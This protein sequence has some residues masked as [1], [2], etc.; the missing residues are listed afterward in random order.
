[1]SSLLASVGAIANQPTIF[2][3]ALVAGTVPAVLWLLFWLR[4]DPEKKEP[5]GLIV[6]TF[7]TGMIAV[8][9]TIPI[10][11]LIQGQFADKNVLLVL[12]A[13]VEEII[14]F[15]VV[16][17]IVYPTG[18]INKPVDLAIY[19][20]ASGL[21]FAALENT[22]FLTRPIGLQETTVA[23][24]TGHL[25]FLGST[26]LH[27]TASAIIGVTAGLVFYQPKIF[28]FLS[29]CTG[30]VLAVALHSTFNFF[31]MKG[32]GQTSLQVFGFLWFV[33]TI[34]VLMFEKLRRMSGEQ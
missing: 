4:E 32:E 13:S 16:A 30:I 1:M 29:L 18:N 10:Q 3:V 25:R 27:A 12:W 33:T 15:I 11:K 23:L 2:L 17:V 34:N 21:G 22:L 14:K 24:L 9:I 28:R 20:I 6:L 7:I 26:L 31:I 5:R 19:C 8:I